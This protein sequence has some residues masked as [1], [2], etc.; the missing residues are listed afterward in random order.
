MPQRAHELLQRAR[1]IGVVRTDHLGDMVLTLPLARVLGRTFPAA[2]IV[3]IAHSRTAPLVEGTPVVHRCVFVDRVPL[4]HLLRSERFDALFFVYPRPEHAWHAWRQRVPLRIGSAYRWWSVLYNV[5]IPD[6]RSRALYHEA[7]YNVRMLE[8][9]TGERYGVEL[10]PPPIA[11]QARADVERFLARSGIAP[12][13]PFVVLH[14][15]GRGSAPRWT[16]FPEL[17]VLLARM[18]P[19]FRIVV[20]GN[21][22]DAPLGEAITTALPSALDACGKLSL[23]QAIALLDR[24]QVVVANS[25]GIL[26]IAAALGR[27][28]VGLYPSEP[29]ALSP[30]RWR[31]LAQ[32]CAVLAAPTLDAIAVEHVADAVCD[33]VQ[34]VSPPL[35]H[36]P[37]HG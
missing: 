16:K 10:V 23:D 26:H 14:P 2:E 3:L 22:A 11:E 36:E 20:T 34:N 21:A 17:A 30:A 25:T 1:R 15:G 35:P 19:S 24:A 31:P 29:P 32:R 8:H 7:E 6:H 5:R 37:T 27:P 9:I 28:V 12:D 4:E 13:E 18:L 33:L